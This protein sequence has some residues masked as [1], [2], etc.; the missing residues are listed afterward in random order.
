MRSSHDSIS[1]LVVSASL[2]RWQDGT[3]IERDGI[4]LQNS[5]EPYIVRHIIDTHSFCY[6]LAYGVRIN[7]ERT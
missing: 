4:M 7:M 2:Q 1:N 5:K 3:L 6:F